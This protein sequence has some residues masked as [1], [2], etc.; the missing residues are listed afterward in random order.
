MFND[1]LARSSGLE[2]GYDRVMAQLGSENGVDLMTCLANLKP[3]LVCFCII[4]R[5]IT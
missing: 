2:A 5:D 4:L 1:Y 3:L